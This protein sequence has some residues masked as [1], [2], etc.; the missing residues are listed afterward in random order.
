[1]Y[2]KVRI[3]LS[4]TATH[5]ELLPLFTQPVRFKVFNFPNTLKYRRALAAPSGVSDIFSLTYKCNKTGFL[6]ISG[7]PQS[8]K[9]S[10]FYCK[11]KKYFIPCR[12]Y[13]VYK[14]YTYKRAKLP[15]EVHSIAFV[16][17]HKHFIVALSE[18]ANRDKVIL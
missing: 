6:E 14:N 9:K 1:M 16:H 17:G 15:M 3:K 4:E 11:R 13:G 7:V 18:L 10:L 12:Y 8:R 5:Y 2:R